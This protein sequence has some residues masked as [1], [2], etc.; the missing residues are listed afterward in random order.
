VGDGFFQWTAPL[1]FYR[2]LRRTPLVVC[3]ERW[4][5]TERGAQWYRKLYRRI[6]LRL[7]SA[8]SCNG[9]LS[10]DYTASLR[11]PRERITTGHMAAD[12]DNLS[13]QARAVPLAEITRLR[14]SLNVRG[15]LL[16]YV[17]QLIARKG[18]TPL[19]EAW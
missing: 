9:K 3:Y 1:L 17:G 14:E 10:A 4:S 16:L 19:L 18:L 6:A 15:T 11:F 13:A 8:V 2:M 7:A 12:T 5:H